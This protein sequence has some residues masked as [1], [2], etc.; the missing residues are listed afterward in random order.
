MTRNEIEKKWQK[1][2]D[3]S[4]VFKA[5]NNSK[6]PKYYALDMFPYPSG[7][8]L[9]IGHLA[10]YTP[11]DI[12]SR[13]KRAQGFNV[14][15][16]MGWDAFGLPAEQ[17]AIQTGVHP[18]ETT[19]KAIENFKRQL[20]SFGFSFDWSR[21]VSTCDA[22]FYKWTQFIFLKLFE[23]GLAYQKEVPVNWCPALKTVLANE[24][25][26]DG[27]SERGGHPVIRVP[28]K[29][30]MLKI[31]SY[32]DRLAEDLDKVDW[33]ERTKEAQRNWIGKSKGA[34]IEFQIANSDQKFKV[35]TTRP[36]TLFGVTFMVFAPEHPLV[37]KISSQEQIKSVLDYIQ[38]SASKSEVDRKANVEKTGCF[39]G[40]F[41]VHPY[42]KAEVP[43]WIA[44]YVLM[45]YGSGAIMSVPAHD[46]RDFEFATQFK[47]PM[48]P[49]VE[50]PKLNEPLPFTGEGLC[51]NSQFLNGL[52][53]SEAIE[54]IIHSLEEKKIGTMQTQYK[55]RDW[56][57]SRQ[58]YWGE[59]F[60]MVRFPERGLA[61][62]P[63]NELP[64]LLPEVA[65][66]EPSE[67]GEAPLA[68]NKDWVNYKN[69][70]ARETD[71]MPGS[72]GSS[73]YFL[74]FT[75][76]Q[77]P[78][79]FANFENQ[80]YWMPV[81]LY[82]GGSEH[83]VGHLLYSRFWQ[84]V[85]F[86][87]G[88]VSHDEPF[89]KLAHQGMILG[90]DGEKMSKSRGNV[91][92][93]DEIRDQYGADVLRTYICFLGPVDKDKPWNDKGIDGIR[94][95]LDRVER[96][97]YNENGAISS[98]SSG[99][100]T[101]IAQDVPVPE[102]L[103]RLL[104]KTI[105]KVTEDLESMNFNTAISAMMILVNE[106]YRSEVRSLTLV[107]TLT[108]LMMPF[109]PHLAEEIWSKLKLP[110]LCSQ[111]PW[112]AFDTALCKDDVLTMG[113][114]VNG[115]MRGTVEV[116]LQTEEASAVAMALEISSVVQALNGQKPK[117]VIYKVGKIL[118]LIG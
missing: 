56:L 83:T 77:N 29:Q 16:P 94:R 115:K 78:D 14:L 2:W 116:T 88:L 7:V 55:L 32:A 28:M 17:Y 20:K 99:S 101:I 25:I 43:V 23:K 108:Q 40:A 9:H 45:D 36:E 37:K 35:F 81:D 97:A 71:T 62:I 5:E 21:E 60:P 114:Q 8:G 104:H 48:M 75:D 96:L 87:A 91:V 105:K 92:N 109:A 50:N 72:A 103:N 80:K 86:D 34:E 85:L 64:V 68:R 112:P 67:K 76:P 100:H 22:S 98:G 10:S 107:K 6:K 4:D 15:H 93:L 90:S 74:R 41:A 82:V 27:K 117:K 39:T 11:T 24:E 111:A 102:E 26:V 79:A 89:K 66:Y 52:K 61:G 38:K 69:Q 84:K 47:I 54:K 3:T 46:E 73:W 70:G 63:I 30:W 59:P 44:D 33:P 110:G 51:I 95:F 57:F 49:V 13:F 113:V 42:T 106:A 18:A 1:F 12:V 58:R 31:T 53:K 118:N 65:D 19:N